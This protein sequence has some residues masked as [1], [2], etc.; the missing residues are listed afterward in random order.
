MKIYHVEI[1]SENNKIHIHNLFG[2]LP[3]EIED[4][5][6][7]KIQNKIIYLDQKII[8]GSQFRINWTY[9]FNDDII[10]IRYKLYHL[11]LKAK[12][13]NKWCIFC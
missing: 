3:K 1:I 12:P 6:Y 10:H 2:S 13:Q 9:Y 7:E 8:L 4:F 5:I 11:H